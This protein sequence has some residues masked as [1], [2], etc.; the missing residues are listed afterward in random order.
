MRYV[1]LEVIDVIV[2]LAPGLESHAGT[3]CGIKII[4]QRASALLGQYSV[5]PKSLHLI[6]SMAVFNK[7]KNAGRL[8]PVKFEDAVKRCQ[9]KQCL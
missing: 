2:Y 8:A 9:T 6:A 5:T 7:D 4:Y 3:V 1:A